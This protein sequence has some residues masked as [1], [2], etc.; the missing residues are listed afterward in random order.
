MRNILRGCTIEGPWHDELRSGGLHICHIEA[1]KSNPALRRYKLAIKLHPRENDGVKALYEE[2]I[3]NAEV[4]DSASQL[5][6]LLG[7][8]WIHMTV[9]STTLYEAAQFGSPTILVPFGNTKD[10]ATY[11]FRVIC[12][13][14]SAPEAALKRLAD[15]KEYDQ[16]LAYLVNETKQYM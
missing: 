6:D 13:D 15:K 7:R 4:Y 16:Y 8:S 11:G 3:S 5:Y 12:L 14:V 10:E 1:L 2:N 9:S